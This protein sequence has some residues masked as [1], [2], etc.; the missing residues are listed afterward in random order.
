MQSINT[1]LIYSD[2]TTP[3]LDRLREAL[4]ARLR[5]LDI[6]LQS[7]AAQDPHN[8]VFSSPDWQ[9]V[10]S[11]KAG[12][13]LADTFLGAMDSVL[14]Q[15]VIGELCEILTQHKSHLQITVVPV[16]QSATP[17]AWLAAQRV[18][19][20]VTC[21]VTEARQ[22]AAVF[23]RPSHQ[24]LT[25]GQYAQMAAEPNPWPLFANACE[26]KT[27]GPNRTSLRIDNAAD[28]IG[29]PILFPETDLSLDLAYS[30]ALAFLRHA[31]ETGAPIPDGHNFGPEDGYV[32]KVTHATATGAQPQGSFVL[33]SVRAG[34]RLSDI[35]TSARTLPAPLPLGDALVLDQ[36]RERTRS[37][38]ISY[39]MLVLLPPVGLVLLFSNA[40]LRP[41]SG[42]TGFVAMTAL[43]IIMVIGAYTFLNIG[44]E[45]TAALHRPAAIDVRSLTD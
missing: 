9:I 42:R 18:A 38:A 34:N 7:D 24:L 26:V 6:V 19:H 35:D 2:Q 16:S 45:D 32:V 30:A 29:R 41:S 20:A 43:A 27:A 25:G 8:A 1:T 3:H 44:A 5:G 23:W 37:L 14:S 4:N 28:F 12:P 22:P 21:V 13:L 17:A 39:L 33:R 11:A 15:T 10:L 31:V 36:T 40:L